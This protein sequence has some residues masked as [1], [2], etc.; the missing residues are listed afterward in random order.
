MISKGLKRNFTI[1][2][3]GL[4][5]SDLQMVRVENRL[6]ELLWMAPSGSSLDLA[7]S[8]TETKHQV[9]LSLSSILF[10]ETVSVESELNVEAIIDRSVFLMLEKLK[11]WKLHRFE[12]TLQ[13]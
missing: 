5:S 1:S 11:E 13:S 7:I 12:S 10:T 6:K 2:L 4:E 8:K 3:D 9:D